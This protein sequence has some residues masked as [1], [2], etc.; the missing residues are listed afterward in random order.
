MANAVRNWVTGEC[1]TDTGCGLKAFRR[2]CLEPLPRFDGMHRFFPTLVKM[3]GFRVVEV[4]VNHR[5]RLRGRTHYNIFNRSIRPLIDL[6][7]VRWLQRRAI[8]VALREEHALV[9]R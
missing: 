5:P 3:H 4:P 7:G 1:V 9:E 6:F 2:E 8:T